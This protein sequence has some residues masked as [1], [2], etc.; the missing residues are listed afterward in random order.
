MTTQPLY[1][2]LHPLYRCHH[3][4]LIDDITP[5]VCMNSHPLH[6]WHYRNFIWHQIH[7]WWHQTFVCLSWHP[8]F[9]GHHIH[10]IWSHTHCLYDYTS[11]ISYPPFLAIT[12]SP[13]ISHAVLAWHHTRPMYGKICTIK[14]I[15]SSLYDIKPQFLGRHTHYIWHRIH[16]I[17]VIT[18]TVLMIPHQLYIWVLLRYIRRHHIHCIRRHIHYIFNITATVSVSATP[19]LSMLSHPLYVWHHTHYMYNIIKTL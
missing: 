7:S 1:P 13:L 5:C 3:T 11:S 14:D 15:A 17:C 18:S 4:H 6:V 9:L 8:V 2:T 10:Y 16:C 19:T 12:N